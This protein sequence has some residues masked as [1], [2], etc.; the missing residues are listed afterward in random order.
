MNVL[1]KKLIRK[2]LIL[3]FLYYIYNI[4]YYNIISI[5]NLLQ[6]LKIDII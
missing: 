1:C 6:I 4:N 2:T 3:K 5:K